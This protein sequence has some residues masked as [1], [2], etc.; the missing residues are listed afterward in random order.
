MVLLPKE[1]PTTKLFDD[2]D[3]IIMRIIGLLL[4]SASQSPVVF[5]QTARGTQQVNHY[6]MM[7]TRRRKEGCMR[8]RPFDNAF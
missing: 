2:D 8:S 3:R 7:T 1:A 6:K 5:V 4:K